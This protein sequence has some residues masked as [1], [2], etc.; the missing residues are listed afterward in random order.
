[1]EILKSGLD[2][3]ID[4][5]NTEGDAESSEKWQEVFGPKIPLVKKSLNPAILKKDPPERVFLKYKHHTKQEHEPQRP[6][7]PQRFLKV[8]LRD[9]PW[10]CPPGQVCDLS[11]KK[12]LRNSL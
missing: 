2:L 5:L 6:R 10:H 12:P 1:M 4:A 7:S 9:L 11:G 8:F 3:A